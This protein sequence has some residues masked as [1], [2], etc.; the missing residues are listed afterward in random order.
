M[1][2]LTAYPQDVLTGHTGVWTSV[3]GVD[4]YA[5]QWYRNGSP[6][7]GQGGN[8]GGSTVQYIVADTDLGSTISLAVWASNRDG[9]SAPVVSSDFVIIGSPPGELGELDL[10][11][12]DQSGLTKTVIG[13]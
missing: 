8:W 4:G 6:I 11:S 2:S 10:S 7:S 1:A 12:A 13:I 3:D 9:T 5:Y